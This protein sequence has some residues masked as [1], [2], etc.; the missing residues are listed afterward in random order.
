MPLPGEPLTVR[1]AG[2]FVYPVKACA[3][4][5]LERADLEER[6]LADD[7]RW[8]VVDP[9]GRA[10]TQRDE[11]RLALVRP[12]LAQGGPWLAAQGAGEVRLEAGAERAECQVWSSRVDLALAREPASRW[13]AALLGR[14]V[15]LAHLDAAARRNVRAIEGGPALE[16]S[17]ADELP[18]LVAAVESLDALN[19]RLARA[20]PMDRFRPNLVLEGAP[21]FAEDGW[22]R[23]A[24]GAVELELLKPA[25]RC[26]V[27]CVDQTRG[28]RD[29][30]GEPLRAL[31]AFR[32]APPRPQ[33]DP[34]GVY[35]GV[36][37]AP[38]TT[39]ALCRGDALRVLARW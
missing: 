17:L 9:S 36:R 19:A 4:L 8:M 14:P 15:R 32:R 31:A 23:V 20:V 39:G 5:A 21:A 6:G 27:V 26:A 2:L 7:R 35:F 11:P 25:G 38:A 30:D 34:G 1:L 16:V 33:A 28:E 29:P 13:L 3:G 24:L 12:R 37:A 22:R 10:L 18:L